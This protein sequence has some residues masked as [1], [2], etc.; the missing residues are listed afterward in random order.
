MHVI[1]ESRDRQELSQ[2]LFL[3]TTYQPAQVGTL[4]RG[5]SLFCL[6]PLPLRLHEVLDLLSFGEPAV[7]TRTARDKAWR[8]T[9]ESWDTAAA[10]VRRYVRNKGMN[11]STLRMICTVLPDGAPGMKATA[12]TYSRVSRSYHGR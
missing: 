1:G 11:K 10:L 9:R 8:V 5:I 6:P 3:R 12:Y 2:C 4:S 7:C